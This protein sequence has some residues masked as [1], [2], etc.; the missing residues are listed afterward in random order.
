MGPRPSVI[1]RLS[2]HPAFLAGVLLFAFSPTLTFL[3]HWDALFAGHVGPE[4]SVV[5]SSQPTMFDITA[6]QAAEQAEQIEHAQH[7]HTE[8]GS[9]SG[10][11]V[12][13]GFGLFI[14]REV[15]LRPPAVALAVLRREMHQALPSLAAA[16]PT[17]PPRDS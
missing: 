10:Q 12:P 4:Q 1:R 5:S 15:L 9:C 7:C 13:A 16:P 14:M 3:G 11:P 8:L 6:E 17:P 2:N